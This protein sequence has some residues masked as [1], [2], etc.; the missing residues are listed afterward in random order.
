MKII[1]E[2]FSPDGTPF[3]KEEVA[4]AGACLAMASDYLRFGMGVSI[5]G[6]DAFSIAGIFLAVSKANNH[7]S[8]IGVTA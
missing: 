8:I 2:T 6:Q 5:N 4:D 1:L 7:K 3:A